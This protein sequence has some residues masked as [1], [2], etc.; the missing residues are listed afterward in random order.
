MSSSNSMMSE[1]AHVPCSASSESSLSNKDYFLRAAVSL[2]N[3]AV[4][5]I[6]QNAYRQARRCLKDSVYIL[7]YTYDEGEHSSQKPDDCQEVFNPSS[8]LDNVDE[9]CHEETDEMMCESTIHRNQIDTDRR[10][11]KATQCLSN[12]R[13]SL[14][15]FRFQVVS[16]DA[17]NLATVLR[18]IN[19][20]TVFE[21]DKLRGVSQSQEV[22]YP[23]RIETTDDLINDQNLVRAIVTYNLGLALACLTTVTQSARKAHQQCHAAS[24]ILRYSSRVLAQQQMSLLKDSDGER[25]DVLD[26]D[27]SV[28]A[29]RLLLVEVLTLQA[30]VFCLKQR[31]IHHERHCRDPRCNREHGRAAQMMRAKCR[32]VYLQSM[33]LAVLED[34]PFLYFCSFHGDGSEFDGA[35]S[36]LSAQRPNLGITVPAAPAA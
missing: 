22:F 20:E 3:T 24:R 29:L 10:L 19:A 4:S 15:S 5:L 9:D 8:D 23:L 16:D 14:Y 21:T 11:R 34:N 18:T 32:L 35:L 33:A 28:E 2:N 30:L 31:K 1:K 7:R 27:Q 12:P 26:S 25:G 36:E 17:S 6:E 13:K